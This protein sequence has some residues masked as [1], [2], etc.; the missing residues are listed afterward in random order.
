MTQ[1]NPQQS[2]DPDGSGKPAAPNHDIVAAI[3]ALGEK[4][5]ASQKGRP[6]H[7][8]Q[9]L[10][11]AKRATIGVGLYTL[12]TVAILAAAIYSAW[13][14][15][16]TEIT[17]LRAYVS[18]DAS[19]VGVTDTETML[20]LDNFGQTP[21]KDV[22]IWSSWEFVPFGEDLP[23]D[24]L[25]LVKPPC[26]GGPPKQ[27]IVP[28]PITVWPKNPIR[29]HGYHC[30]DDA[31]QLKRAANNEINAFMYGFI[32]YLDIFDRQRRTNFCYLYYPAIGTALMCSR[33]NEIDPEKHYQ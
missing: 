10:K 19:K 3:N 12:I 15:R 22:H 25:F 33:H 8:E 27:K 11:W 17:S 4:Y 7:D 14:S 32:T 29:S 16:D 9:T 18:F 24:F 13:T 20:F 5:E 2:D 1:G 30:P 26:G 23:A 31:V 21:A 28:G 6:E